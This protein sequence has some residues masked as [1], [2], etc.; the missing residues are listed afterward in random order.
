MGIST[1][2]LLV[3]VL[4][5]LYRGLFS[6]VKPPLPPGPKGLPLVGS[7]LDF[8]R[9]KSSKPQYA[10]YLDMGKTYN[11]DVL[12][13]NVL[14]DHTIVLNSVKATDELLEK[15]SAIYSDRPP[16]YMVNDLAGWHWDPAHLRYS[17]HW[18]LHR[19]LLHQYFQPRAVNA[20]HPFQR[21]EASVL[22]RKLL[23][24]PDDLHSHVRQHAGSIILRV[25]YGMTSQEDKDYYTVVANRAIQGLIQAANHGSYLVDFFPL[26]K[27]VPSWFPGAEFKRKAKVWAQYATELREGPWKKLQ[28]ATA[29]CWDK[30]SQLLCDRIP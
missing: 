15:R 8:M 12:H 30:Y 2:L 5:I 7:L 22:L 16:M 19:K 27:Y 1:V 24:S 29:S 18:R 21:K 14:G 11:S 10:K 17:D 3:P 26:L 6:R 28:S 25:S 13:I 4:W 23:Q 9:D 20:Y